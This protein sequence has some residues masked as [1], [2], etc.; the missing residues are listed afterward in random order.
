[1]PDVAR[2]RLD[3]VTPI[4][5]PTSESGRVWVFPHGLGQDGVPFVM[6]GS[7][8]P[9]KTRGRHSHHGD[10]VY[11]YAAGE[12]HVEG[13]GIYRAGDVRWCRA[14]TV[15]GPETTGP[16]GGSWW[17]VSAANPVPIDAR[18]VETAPSQAVRQGDDPARFAA[19]FDWSAIDAAVLRSGAAIVEGLLDA[20]ARARLDR[21]IDEQL[22]HH[23]RGGLPES[24]SG[25]YDTF[26]GHR[27]RRLHGLA[28]KLASGAA[29]IAHS[30]ITAWA[31]RM[32]GPGGHS[33]LLNAGELIEIGPG[34]PAQ[35]LH[36]DTD[37]WPL[38]A[39]GG[40]P[41]VVNAILALD[42]FTL[43]TGATHVAI[44][45]HAWERAR[46]AGPSE[47]SRAT[48]RSGDALLFRG[49]VLHG[50]GANGTADRRRRG[51]SLSYCVGWLRPVENSWLNVPPSVA[52][53][54]PRR[55]QEL[56]GYAV[57]DA[58]S[59][60]GGVLGQFE[61]GDPRDLLAPRERASGA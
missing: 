46:Q 56:L 11:F 35:L 27:T 9:H 34:E 23:A 39:I 50:G 58:T 17:I 12:H 8:P 1:M 26:L 40:D 55:A 6:R 15:Y 14:G 44:G 5:D 22:A 54:L 24:G 45:S 47:L 3:D 30:E 25:L 48:M 57:H 18:D 13:E 33:I 32:L 49:D 60:G 41:V 10:V 61:M 38:L 51:I 4:D 21:E 36:R 37:S 59:V 28:A 42:A 19:P 53:T 16:A 7:D 52:A 2:F 43:E 31:G 29:L 20:E